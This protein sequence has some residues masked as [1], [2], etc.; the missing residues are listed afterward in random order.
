MLKQKSCMTLL[1]TSSHYIYCCN[2]SPFRPLVFAAG[3]GDGRLY[4]YDLQVLLTLLIILFTSI[5]HYLQ[6]SRVRASATIE[7]GALKA[8]ILALSF[9]PKQRDFIATGELL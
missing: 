6:K 4:I 8:P 9:N 1:P 7:A 3:S 2:W 5:T